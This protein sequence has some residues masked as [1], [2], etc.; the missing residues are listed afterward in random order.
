MPTFADPIQ[1]L[2]NWGTTYLSYQTDDSTPITATVANNLLEVIDYLTWTQHQPI[3]RPTVVV[4]PIR[5]VVENH[6]NI[7][8]SPQSRKDLRYKIELSIWAKKTL[9]PNIGGYNGA[10]GLVES[11]LSAVITRQTKITD[12]NTSY[13]YLLLSIDTGPV[14]NPRDFEP[15]TDQHH[16][17]YI[18]DL[19][20]QTVQ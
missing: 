2:I 6:Y 20:R 1:T 13:N 12:V 4:G 17:V 10:Y 9:N 16:V 14:E 11:V 7:G 18:L 5:R 15:T 3:D 19:W 8:D